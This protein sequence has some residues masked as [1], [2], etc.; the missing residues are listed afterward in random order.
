VHAEAAAVR[1]RQTTGERLGGQQ[2]PH[3]GH[4]HRE[5]RRPPSP[6]VAS[7]QQPDAAGSLTDDQRGHQE[8]RGRAS[9]D[10]VRGDDLDE[11]AEVA[12]LA[13]GHGHQQ[14]GEDAA[15]HGT[16]TRRRHRLFLGNSRGPAP[17]SVRRETTTNRWTPARPVAQT[18][19]RKRRNARWGR[20]VPAP[21]INSSLGGAAR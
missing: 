12:E 4:R 10:L 15:R 11:A 19:G 17:G 18:T 2:A 8:G 3:N 7:G 14:N 6:S 21:T 13:G 16:G 1:H 9:G 20:R 5:A